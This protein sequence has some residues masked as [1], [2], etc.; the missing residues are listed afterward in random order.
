MPRRVVLAIVALVLLASDVAAQ[1]AAPTPTPE[2]N[3]GRSHVVA[4]VRRIF[5]T[6]TERLI[7][8]SYIEA[9]VALTD[10]PN[11]ASGGLQGG[12]DAFRRSI[13]AKGGTVR[14]A[15]APDIGDEHVALAAQQ[16]INDGASEL[17]MGFFAWRDGNLVIM[18]LATG[19]GEQLPSLFALAR[20]IEGRQPGPESLTTP[21]PDEM[22]SGGIWDVL[23]TLDDMP[24]GF[25]FDKD[26]IR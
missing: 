12:A 9:Q 14:E 7:G 6:P 4:H 24:E 17:Q 8:P 2:L 22:S 15:S 23:P 3:T 19:Y 13:E 1:T 11:R 18:L 16:P 5:T 21:V 26:E 10:D 25:V 20:T